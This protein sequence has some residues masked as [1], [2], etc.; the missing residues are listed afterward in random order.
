MVARVAY[1]TQGQAW[2]ATHK[3]AGVVVL[4]THP[5]QWTEDTCIQESVY[6]SS[7]QVGRYTGSIALKALPD[8]EALVTWPE[9]HTDG[10]GF[11][12]ALETMR[13]LAAMGI[14]L[15]DL[16]RLAVQSRDADQMPAFWEDLRRRHFE[17]SLP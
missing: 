17:V 10:V 5:T 14:A 16:R 7:I 6:R 4:D 8:E 12:E 11:L 3:A 2:T 9:G 13:R 15:R 1:Y